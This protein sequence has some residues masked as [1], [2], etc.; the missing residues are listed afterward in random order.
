MAVRLALVDDDGGWALGVEDQDGEREKTVAAG[1]VHDARAG[2]A[3]AVGVSAGDDEGRLPRLEEFLARE[4]VGLAHGAR[5]EVKI[6]VAR[7]ARGIRG[8]QA[9]ARPDPKARGRNGT[10]ATALGVREEIVA[11]HRG[12][13]VANRGVAHAL[14]LEAIHG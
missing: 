3:E 11:P 12:D 4:D 10:G 2:T 8:R 13:E 6:V 9:T 7:E 14:Q 1:E 5:D